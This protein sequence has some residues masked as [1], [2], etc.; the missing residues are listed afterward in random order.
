MSEKKWRKTGVIVHSCSF[1]AP[2]SA[3]CF[4]TRPVFPFHFRFCFVFAVPLLYFPFCFFFPLRLPAFLFGVIVVDNLLTIT[5]SAH[6]ASTFYCGLQTWNFFIW[7]RL[8]LSSGKCPSLS[9][10][11]VPSLS[12]ALHALFNYF[13]SSILFCILPCF[14][15]FCFN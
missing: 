10:R 12:H 8:S 3:T 1:V 4:A 5:F 2:F 9:F 7:L 14:V 13:L 11:L 15:L 6:F